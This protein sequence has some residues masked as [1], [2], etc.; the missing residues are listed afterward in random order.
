MWAA[1]CYAAQC[2]LTSICS[3]SGCVQRYQ[4]SACLPHYWPQALAYFQKVLGT[5]SKGICLKSIHVSPQTLGHHWL[6]LGHKSGSVSWNPDTVLI[7]TSLLFPGQ[8]IQS[9]NIFTL[10]LYN[11]S[12]KHLYAPTISTCTQ[13]VLVSYYKYP[14]LGIFILSHAIQTIIYIDLK[15]PIKTLG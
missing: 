14:D 7:N 6:V 4:S 3:L 13:S 5:S 2:Y 11:H 10:R 8:N 1:S 9:S 15:F 12:P